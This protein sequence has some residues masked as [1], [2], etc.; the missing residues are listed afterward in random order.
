VAGLF[1]QYYET[2]VAATSYAQLREAAGYF[3]SAV[4]GGLLDVLGI[5]GGGAALTRLRALLAKG[6]V[7]LQSWFEAA[8]TIGKQLWAR[9]RGSGG[10]MLDRL[11]KGEREKAGGKGKKAT[12]NRTGKVP[13][14]ST[15]LSQEALKYRQKNNL[16]HDG[17]VAV[18]E[19]IDKDGNVVR[20]VFTTTPES[21]KHA[22]R[23][24]W[25]SLKSE[26]V[27]PENVK[28]VY[29][30][31]EPCELNGSN[32]KAELN[33]RFPNAE[34]T[35]SYDY[36]GSTAETRVLRQKAIEQRRADFEKHK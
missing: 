21:G 17:N 22:E 29:S 8:V 28:R 24:G 32:C 15:D 19:Y 27:P 20:R 16:W 26:G 1:K 35:H 13:Y 12:P 30:E 33:N 5:L 25:E 9:L 34:K 31:L 11:L 18:Y 6:W 3:S 2:A 10:R 36:P 7:P 23:I 4:L 14:G